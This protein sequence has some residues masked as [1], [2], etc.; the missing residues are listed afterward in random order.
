MTRPLAGR[1][2]LV[3]GASR[4]GAIGAAVARRLAEDG[5]DLLLHSWSPHDEEQPWGADAGGPEALAQ[6]LGGHGVRVEQVS[7]DLADPTA[8]ARLV[9]AAVTGF[10]HLDALVAVHARSS[11]QSLEELTVEELDLSW[12]VN[13]RATLLLVQAF[14][15]AHDDARNGGRVLLFTSGQDHGAMPGELPYIAS[16]AVLHQ[17]TRSLAVHLA[18]R[19]IPVNA[20]DPGPTDTGW[21]DAD[22]VEA[23]AGRWSTPSDVA[24]LVGWLLSDEADWITGQVLRS[25]GGWAAR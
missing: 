20:V 22:T 7:A 21:A 15:A 11:S 14:A 23:V 16:K 12:A 19:R 2:V 24:R 25:D 4:R 1:T 5:A 6:E 9:E 18:P 3:T 17:L 13:A 10:G 8:A